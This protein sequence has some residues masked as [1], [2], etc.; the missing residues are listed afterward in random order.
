MVYTINK[1]RPIV[2]LLTDILDYHSGYTY[3]T[4]FTAPNCSNTFLLG[5][6]KTLHL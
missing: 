4:R 6:R 5:N 3:V 2:I 1:N